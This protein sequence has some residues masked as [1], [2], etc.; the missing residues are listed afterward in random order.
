MSNTLYKLIPVLKSGDPPH[1]YTIPV[2][3]QGGGGTLGGPATIADGADVTEGA[4]TDAAVVT[5]ANGTIS[6]KLRGL[7]VILLRA[8]A[9]GTPIRIDPVGSTAQPVTGTFYQ[10][11]QPSSPVAS[12]TGGATPYHYIAAAAANQDSNVIKAS[13]GQL[14]SISGMCAVATPRFLKL[15]NKASAPTSSDTPVHTLMMP[16]NGTTGAGFTLAIPV[17]LTFSA[18]IAFR[19]TTGLADNDTGACTAGD[20][21]IN[22]GWI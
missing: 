19:L 21:V 14:Y 6:G 5:D 20:C 17:G 16:A 7:I 8:F 11:T 15:Y 9:L 10:A 4:T 2:T 1:E 12:T 13:A 3:L 22:L 18:G